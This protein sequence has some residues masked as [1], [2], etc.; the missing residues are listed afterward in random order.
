[1]RSPELPGLSN[2]SAP[3]GGARLTELAIVFP[4]LDCEFTDNMDF[5]FPFICCEFL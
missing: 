4:S 2:C 1:M 5:L 3:I